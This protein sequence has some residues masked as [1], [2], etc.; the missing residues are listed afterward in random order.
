MLAARYAAISRILMTVAVRFTSCLLAVRDMT[1]LAHRCGYG[2]TAL[3]EK[4]KGKANTTSRTGL[5]ARPVCRSC[6]RSTR[7]YTLCFANVTEMSATGVCKVYSNY[8]RSRTANGRQVGVHGV[9]TA[10]VK[11]ALSVA[12]PSCDKQC[13]AVRCNVAAHCRVSQCGT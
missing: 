5:C 11:L 13:F 10:A 3:P 9:N 1:H 8:T 7:A 4:K 12:A 6:F 2:W